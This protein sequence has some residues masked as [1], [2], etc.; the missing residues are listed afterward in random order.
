MFETEHIIFWFPW[1]QFRVYLWRLESLVNHE[2][3]DIEILKLWG[4][5]QGLRSINA[6]VG[7]KWKGFFSVLHLDSSGVFPVISLWKS[8]FRNKLFWNTLKGVTGICSF[9]AWG[10]LI[11]NSTT[12]FYMIHKHFFSLY[13]KC[14]LVL[15]LLI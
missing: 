11:R 14:T 4:A 6:Q 7:I 12:I 2:N 8:L 3:A 9:L 1:I 13:S 15:L 5:K 10:K